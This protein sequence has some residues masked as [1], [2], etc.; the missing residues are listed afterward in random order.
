MEQNIKM[1]IM[2]YRLVF[3]YN[4]WYQIQIIH[5]QEYIAVIIKSFI[6]IY[7]SMQLVMD[8][9]ADEDNICNTLCPGCPT[10][11]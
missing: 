2:S 7:Q 5:D 10:I 11:L 3:I 6:F 4:I 8:I 1:K 9:F